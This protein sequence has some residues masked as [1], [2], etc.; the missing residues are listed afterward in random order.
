M[1]NLMIAYIVI[2]ALFILVISGLHIG[3]ALGTL[4]FI[5][6]VLI[7]G[8]VDRGLFIL[9]T[10]S[11]E[12]LRSY[13][14]AVVPLFILMGAFISNT[15]IASNLYKL[16]NIT[17]RRVPGGLSLATVLTNT[18]FAAVTGTSIASAATVSRISVPEMQKY[19]YD[20]NFA[21]ANVAGSSTLGMLIPPSLMFIL[22]GMLAEVSI[23]RLFIAGIVPGILLAIM[24]SIGVILMAIYMPR[25]V[26]Q[27]GYDHKTEMQMSTERAKEKVEL[28]KLVRAVAPIVFIIILIMGGIWGGLFTPTEAAAVGAFGALVVSLFRGIGLSGLKKAILEAASTTASVMFLIVCANMY[29][30]MLALS[31]LTA[32]ITGAIS[33]LD[34]HRVVILILFM[35][36]I[37]LVALVLDSNSVMLLT[38]PLMAPIMASLGY[39]L[40]WFGVI[41]V[42][43]IHTGLITPPFGLCVFVI[44]S[45]LGDMVNVERIFIASLPFLL[46]MLLHAAICIIFPQLSL[47][48][49]SLM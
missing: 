4:S 15:D 1:D 18:V 9:A 22:Y 24:F 42:L 13:V 19:H 10:T 16:L 2:A 25:L 37:M 3:F 26:Y 8:T 47:F 27:P 21:S 41:L 7:T 46:V 39:D 38:V 34:V 17:L 44:K 12:V 5:G 45:T 33:G 32:T 14:F 48:L 49:P 28:V 40:V 36:T 11:F 43:F 35:I 20:V 31:G 29:S 23:G 6:I 30:R